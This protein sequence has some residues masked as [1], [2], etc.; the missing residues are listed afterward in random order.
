[1]HVVFLLVLFSLASSSSLIAHHIAWLKLC[2][3][4]IS[5]MHEAS[6]TLRL[7]SSPFHPT[8]SSPYS[9][10]I[11][12]SSCCPFTSTRTS[13]NTVY[14]ANKEMGVYGRILP[15]NTSGID[16]CSRHNMWNPFLELLFLEHVNDI[17]GSYL[18]DF[19]LAMIAFSC[20]F[21]LDL[22]CY[23]ECS[24]LHDDT[25]DTIVHGVSSWY[26][27]IASVWEM[28]P[29]FRRFQEVGSAFS[30]IVFRNWVFQFAWSPL[31]AS[32]S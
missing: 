30:Y 9:S 8:S 28:I 25:L 19:D 12:R 2:A 17:V 32:S 31:L 11:S 3:C 23:K 1:M 22:L 7:L 16:D 10:S 26:G 21:A 13:S 24:P 20:H 27:T 18:V 15:P 29:K 6:V 5:S 14:S 4:L